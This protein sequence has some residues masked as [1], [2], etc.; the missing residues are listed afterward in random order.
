M[1][2]AEKKFDCADSI[3]DLFVKVKWI[4][5]VKADKYFQAYHEEDC[6]VNL[7]IDE[8]K[9]LSS[10]KVRYGTVLKLRTCIPNIFYFDFGLLKES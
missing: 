5:L 1:S 4:L 8:A 3:I 10:M 9:E 2:N 6:I 7:S